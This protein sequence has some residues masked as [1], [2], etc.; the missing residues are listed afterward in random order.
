MKSYIAK[1]TS[2]ESKA[3]IATDIWPPKTARKPAILH[4]MPFCQATA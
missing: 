2:K 1:N 4:P 3:I